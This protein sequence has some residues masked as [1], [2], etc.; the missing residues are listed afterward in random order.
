M[1]VAH[2][3][4]KKGTHGREGKGHKATGAGGRDRTDDQQRAN[5]TAHR[6]AVGGRRREDAR[7]GEER[8]EEV[9]HADTAGRRLSAVEIAAHADST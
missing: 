7:R 4:Q 1:T 9:R 2:N 6:R 5:S 3:E 8:K